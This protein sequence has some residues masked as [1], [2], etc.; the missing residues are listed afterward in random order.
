M[1]VLYLLRASSINGGEFL[2]SSIE[3]DFWI[4]SFRMAFLVGL[5]NVIIICP[6]VN[7]CLGLVFHCVG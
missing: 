4:A 3:I 1:P 7:C 2:T 5:L 6:F